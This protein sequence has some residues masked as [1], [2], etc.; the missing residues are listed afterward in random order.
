MLVPKEPIVD[1]LPRGLRVD[2]IL[3][4]QT[5]QP[6]QRISQ[7]RRLGI[8]ERIGI[9]EDLV[10][11]FDDLPLE[12]FFIFEVAPLW[13]SC[14]H[15]CGL[16]GRVF[17]SIP[18]TLEGSPRLRQRCVLLDVENRICAFLLSVRFVFRTCL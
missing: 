16:L 9:S 1:A 3:L 4:L 10:K 5:A 17:Y 15:S 8:I 18:C 2:Q 6:L 14:G 11:L 13:R 12:P 7:I